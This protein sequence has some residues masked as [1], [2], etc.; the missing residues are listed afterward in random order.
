MKTAKQWAEILVKDKPCL[1]DEEQYIERMARAIQI[2]ALYHAADVS[3]KSL[4]LISDI[5]RREADKL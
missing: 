4:G 1:V 5:V 3:D 2:N